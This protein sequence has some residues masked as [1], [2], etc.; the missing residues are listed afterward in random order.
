MED[1]TEGVLLSLLAEERVLSALHIAETVKSKVNIVHG[2]RKRI[3]KREL[4][5]SI[6]DYIAQHPWLISPQWETFQ[7]EKSLKKFFQDAQIAAEIDEEDEKWRGRMDLV[8]RS[9]SELIV[10]EFMRPGLTADRDHFNR[11]ETYIDT[12]ETQIVR[13][14]TGLGIHRITGLLIADELDRNAANIILIERMRQFNRLCEEWPGLLAQAEK[15]WVD[16]LEAV[17]ERAPDGERLK[18]LVD[19]ETAN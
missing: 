10:L 15:A 7:V 8:L 11:F 4:E 17:V 1:M 14:N 5:N 16:F 3:E 6:R 9:G 19:P 12:L 13:T 18:S 2:L